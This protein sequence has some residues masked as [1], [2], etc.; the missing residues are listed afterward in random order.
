MQITQIHGIVNPPSHVICTHI[1]I[2]NDFYNTAI[3]IIVLL[4]IIAISTNLYCIFPP[5]IKWP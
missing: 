1:L 5:I 2:L 3:E 4:H